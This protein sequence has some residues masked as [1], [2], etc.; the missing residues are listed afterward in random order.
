MKYRL[1]KRSYDTNHPRKI[2]VKFQS[3]TKRDAFYKGRKRTPI[4]DDPNMNIYIN[5]DLTLHRGK[6]FHDARKLAKQH[7]LHSTWTQQGNIMV[8]KN[9]EDRPIAVYD[10]R[11]LRRVF[12]T[13]NQIQHLDSSS[14]ICENGSYEAL[15]EMS[16]S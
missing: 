14:D 6:L 4:S 9:E 8:K 15:D 5:E 12:E 10:N 16:T 2:L 13:S 7:R 3:K 1:G 11:E